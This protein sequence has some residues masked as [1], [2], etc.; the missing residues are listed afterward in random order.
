[1]NRY[2]DYAVPPGLEPFVFVLFQHFQRFFLVELEIASSVKRI[3]EQQ[4]KFLLLVVAVYF[5]CQIGS[6]P[7]FFSGQEEES[8]SASELEIEIGVRTAFFAFMPVRLNTPR[9]DV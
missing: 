2:I 8:Y 1:M 4:E 7:A 3:R 6:E 9:I 5:H